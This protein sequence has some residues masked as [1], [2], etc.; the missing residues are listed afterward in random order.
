[1]KL[2]NAQSPVHASVHSPCKPNPITAVVLQA[3]SPSPRDSRAFP[4]QYRSNIVKFVLIPAVILWIIP[5]IPLS[6]HSLPATWNS[7]PP[8]MTD[9]SVSL[10]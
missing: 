5:P 9:V 6:C 8:R 10:L 1:L 4:T 2:A 7:L 3:L